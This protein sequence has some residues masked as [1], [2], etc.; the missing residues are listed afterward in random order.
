VFDDDFYQEDFSTASELE[1]FISRLG[2]IFETYEI[3][4][5]EPLKTN[6]LWLCDWVI[7]KED[8]LFNDFDLVV[9][10]YRAKISPRETESKISNQVFNDLSS[11][12]NDFCML[13]VNYLKHD[14]EVLN[15][16]KTP[17]I[18]P[19]A[20]FYG[21]RDFVVVKTKR[22]SLTDIS[23]IKLL[24]ASLSLA[25]SESKCKIPAF[26]QVLYHEQVIVLNQK[27]IE[28]QLNNFSFVNDRTYFWEFM[29]QRNKGS[30]LI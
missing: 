20:V 12:E 26:I 6:E 28:L 7:E 29:K 24:Q 3:G 1:A 10:R 23:Q 14:Y 18:H 15:A 27:F 25:V 2:D 19:L 22:K 13:D 17:N 5:E 4:D 8:I 30:H 16:P 11:S 9:T 21:L